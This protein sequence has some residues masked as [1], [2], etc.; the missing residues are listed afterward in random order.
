MGWK[1][2]LGSKKTSNIFLLILI[3]L[4]TL[5]LLNI[6]VVKTFVT[7][8]KDLGSSLSPAIIEIER[9]N[10]Y[11]NCYDLCQAHDFSSGYNAITETASSCNAGES[12]ATLGQPGEVQELF[13]CCVPKPTTEDLHENDCID[14]DGGIDIY[15]PGHA[16]YQENGYYDNCLD[17]YSIK[18][19]F[20]TDGIVYSENNPMAIINNKSLFIGDKINKARVVD[21]SRKNVT[22][23]YNGK[24]ITLTVAKG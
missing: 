5:F 14:S 4:L 2:T 9:G 1:K 10:Y 13:C 8:D 12:F 18:E 7:G 17:D 24:K 23:D 20:C 11:S 6:S 21:I 16:T 15:T 19:Y 3:F 22:L